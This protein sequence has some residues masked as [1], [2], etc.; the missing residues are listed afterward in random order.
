MKSDIP[1]VHVD[2]FLATAASPPLYHELLSLPLTDRELETRLEV[3]VAHNLLNAPGVR[4]WR[5]GT[6]NSGVS[7][8]NRVLERHTSQHGAYWKSYDFAGSVG[9][10][11]IFTHPL[12]FTHDGGEAIFNLPNGLQ[13][14][15][16]ANA[17]GF[18]LDDAPINIVS[19]PA[20]SDPTVRNGLSCFGCH[21]EGMK[22]FED[23]VRSVIESNAT[24]AYDKAQALRLY[25]E[26]SEMDARVQEDM[27]RYRGALEATGGT[28]DDIEPISRFHEVFQGPVDAAYAAAV[29]GLETEAFQ[30]KIRENIGLQNAGLLVLDSENGSMKRD[31]WT[32]SFRDVLF[33]LDFPKLV[34]KPPVVPEPDRLPGAFVHIPDSN[35]RAAIAEALGKSPNS[36][37]T[38]QEMERLRELD[39]RNRDI[40]DLTGLQLATNLSALD[41]DNNEISDISPIAGLINLRR[42]DLVDNPISDISPVRGLT[43]LIKLGLRLTLVS[44]ISPVRGL[45]NLT[46]FSFRGTQVSDLS[47]LAELINLEQLDFSNTSESISDLSPLA[48]L[49]NLKLVRSWNN[50]ISDLSPLAGLTTLEIVDICGGNISNL[51]LLVGLTGLKELYLVN[52]DISDI[53]PLAGLTGLNRLDLGENDI[54]DVSPLASLARLKWLK[55]DNNKISDFSPLDGLRE[56]IK[57]IW[58]HNPA[59]PKVGPAIEGPWLWVVLPDTKPSSSKDLLSEA[60]GG[61]VTEVEI[62]THGAAVGGSVGDDVWTFRKL[63]PTG[64]NNVE[65]MLEGRIDGASLYGAVSLHSPREQETTLYVGSHDEFKVWLNGTLI[66][67]EL[68]SHG[69]SGGYTDFLPVTL[70]EGRNVL[71]VTVRAQYST[72]FGFE[73]GTEYTVANPGV[74]YTFS[75]TPIHTGDTFT[76][77]IRAENVFDLAGWQFDIAFDPAALEAVDVSEGDFLKSNGGTTFFQDGIIDNAAGKITGL[78]AAR[79]SGGGVSG[80]GVL[81]QVRFK[82]KSD[83]ETELALQKFQFGSY[84]VMTFLQDRMKSVSMWRE[85]WQPGM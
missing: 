45:T 20:A 61:T 72:F 39:A 2:W 7:N 67:E 34:D 26:Q 71:L 62:A 18:R 36:P 69:G 65:K 22:T 53:S 37:I 73:P 17:S 68:R 84:R 24:P 38:V 41:L 51:S 78:S 48:G 5:A 77:D 46:I 75:K 42:L 70:Q 16:L 60:S 27:E 10:Q 82:A 50:S 14:Y 74:S 13:G 33:A 80:T 64:W 11:N 43:N 4:V 81:L 12:S 79:L 30:E 55:I 35:L 56:N 66:Y 63:P 23:Q 54:S 9:T 49:I 76:L 47:P 57:L 15:Y 8:N 29:V 31:A 21:T 59:F 40:Q 44:D 83:G 58:H 19:N 6:N 28:V 3:D 52:N 1:S 25:V 32:S 85:D